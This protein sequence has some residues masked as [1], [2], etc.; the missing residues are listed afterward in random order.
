MIYFPQCSAFILKNIT[1]IVRELLW[2][3][4]SKQSTIL[5]Q[6]ATDYQL[7]HLFSH[8]GGGTSYMYPSQ[9]S[10]FVSHLAAILQQ[11]RVQSRLEKEW[12]ECMWSW[13][14]PLLN[15]PTTPSMAHVITGDS[16]SGLDRGWDAITEATGAMCP[17]L[18]AGKWHCV[19]VRA[20]RRCP[21]LPPAY[22]ALPDH[23]QPPSESWQWARQPENLPLLRW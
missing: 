11:S 13:K 15:P 18:R 20:G 3:F 14:N 4:S 8:V 10:H 23:H 5:I 22:G 17:V 16:K 19:N 2:Q 7:T 6:V 21:R 12:E 1:W 9:T